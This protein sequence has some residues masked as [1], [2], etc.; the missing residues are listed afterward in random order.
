ML[1]E[2]SREADRHNA[3]GWAY[4]RTDCEARESVSWL[5]SLTKGHFKRFNERCPEYRET[6]RAAAKRLAQEAERAAKKA[7]K[8][9]GVKDD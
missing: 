8:K 9:V 6:K 3:S 1:P 5:S 7:A 4:G 2:R